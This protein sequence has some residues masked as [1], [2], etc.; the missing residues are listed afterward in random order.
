MVPGHEGE[1]YRPHLTLLRDV[2]EAEVDATKARF[3]GFRPAHT[4]RVDSISLICHYPDKPWQAGVDFPLG[5]LDGRP[6]AH[7]GS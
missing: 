4:F 1:T 7:R 6:A 3:A 5:G 2:P